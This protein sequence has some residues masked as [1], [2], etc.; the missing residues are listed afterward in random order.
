M[1]HIFSKS[2]K[3]KVH[4]KVL[5]LNKKLEALFFRHVP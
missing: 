5:S 1:F 2:K 4:E 3:D